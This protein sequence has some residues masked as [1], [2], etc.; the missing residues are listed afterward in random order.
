MA[1]ATATASCG[2]VRSQR[3]ARTMSRS[4]WRLVVL[5][6]LSWVALLLL[7]GTAHATSSDSRND[8]AAPVASDRQEVP[9]IGKVLSTVGGVTDAL[10]LDR[11]ADKAT[12]TEP[13]ARVVET[14]TKTVASAAETV[15]SATA[16]TD[17]APAALP[18]LNAGD[19]V[20]SVANTVRATAE[21]T[22]SGDELLDVRLPSVTETVAPIIGS[23]TAQ[24]DTTIATAVDTVELLTVPLPVSRPLTGALDAAAGTV[25]AATDLVDAVASAATRTVDSAVVATTSVLAPV[26]G[27]VTGPVG[28]IGVSAPGVNATTGTDTHPTG[29]EDGVTGP[30][31]A[32]AWVPASIAFT[33]ASMPAE[34]TAGGPSVPPPNAGTDSTD[35]AAQPAADIV[36][37]VP[38]PVSGAGSTSGSGGSTTTPSL[39]QTL[40][41]VESEPEFEVEITEPIE[42]PAGPMP[43]TPC[44]DPAFSP[45]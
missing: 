32:G 13:V 4:C 6:G 27:G 34:S 16:V 8:A 45:D 21:A 35:V 28:S 1:V 10:P 38:V 42:G 40:V 18:V 2:L 3:R 39:D 33:T 15:A 30:V 23:V 25:D 37:T 26:L 14:T 17:K 9:L 29:A 22:S 19:A 11:A 31:V 7:G 36:T 24:V 43:G 5:L 20:T 41:R 44:V 12:V